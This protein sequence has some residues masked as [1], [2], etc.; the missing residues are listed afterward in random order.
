MNPELLKQLDEVRELYEK[1]IT[2]TSSYR[3]ADHPIERAKPNGPGVHSYGV[4]VDIAAV[5]GTET[6]ELVRAAIAAGFE[7][8]GVK[9]LYSLRYSG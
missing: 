5:G 8:I 1:P 7:R 3:G 6:L 2:I 4:A 9:K